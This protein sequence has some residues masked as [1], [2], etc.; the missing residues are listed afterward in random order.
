MVKSTLKKQNKKQL[1]LE[2]APRELN[3]QVWHFDM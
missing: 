1:Y 2:P 3:S